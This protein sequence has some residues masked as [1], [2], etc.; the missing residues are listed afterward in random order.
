[1]K[2]WLGRTERKGNRRMQPQKREE[3][4]RKNKSKN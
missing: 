4:S 3:M 2:Q 1:M